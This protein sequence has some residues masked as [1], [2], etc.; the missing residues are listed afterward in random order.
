MG[1]RSRAGRTKQNM[2][3]AEMRR[4]KV[5]A[6]VDAGCYTTYEIA[7]ECDVSTTTIRRDLDA[8]RKLA[9]RNTQEIHA[10]VVDREI[11]A[12]KRAAQL[13]LQG[14]ERSQRDEQTVEQEADGKGKLSLSKKRIRTR[15]GGAQFINAFI[16]A[17][18]SICEI[19]GIIGRD[20]FDAGGTTEAPQLVPVVISTHEEAEQ[21]RLL[22]QSGQA[23]RFDR[24]TVEG[25]V[26]NT[27]LNNT[28]GPEGENDVSD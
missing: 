26:N 14:F 6:M 28:A 20:K 21:Y 3:I 17:R 16:A 18:R 23:L 2:L 10:S 22:S 24:G 13:A 5:W 4:A 8:I 12:F 1:K 27:S 11:A 7:A 19:L 25:V 15:D 9:Q